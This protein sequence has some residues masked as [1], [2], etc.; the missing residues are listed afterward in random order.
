MLARP[1]DGEWSATTAN[2]VIRHSLAIKKLCHFWAVV[3]SFFDRYRAVS[4]PFF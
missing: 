3:R 1:G 4:R 2:R